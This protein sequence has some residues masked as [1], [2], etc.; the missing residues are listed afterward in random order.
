[1]LYIISLGL[2][3]EKDMSLRALET[4]KKCDSIYVELYTD[5]LDT[6]AEKLSALTGKPVKKLARSDLEENVGRILKDAR[7]R[8]VGIMVGGDALAAT[9]HISMLL[10]ARKLG[11]P[12]R[13]I[14]GSSIVSAVAETG[15]QI[16]KF[17]RTTTLTDPVPR[18]CLDCIRMNRDMGLHT[19]ALLD[20]GME[21]R[22]GLELLLPLG[23]KGNVLGVCDLG[24]GQVIRYGH[25]ENLQ[26]DSA[27]GKPGVIIIPGEL[28][29]LEKE[30][31]ETLD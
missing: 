19:L 2:H 9:T 31:L 4:A 14:H 16:Y 30:Y 10:E 21:V 28:H 27:L 15:L 17:G 18:S 26:K 12:F 7:S 6:G 20:I 25:M 8:D 24:G 23:L 5:N 1:M 3:D 29:F 11:I 13:V 22:K